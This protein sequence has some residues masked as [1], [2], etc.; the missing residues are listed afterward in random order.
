MTEELRWDEA[1]IIGM[2]RWLKKCDMLVKDF[3]QS[4]ITYTSIGHIQLGRIPF[5]TITLETI[6]KVI[7]IFL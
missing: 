4:M 1:S 3:E 5:D 2:S 7:E 6:E